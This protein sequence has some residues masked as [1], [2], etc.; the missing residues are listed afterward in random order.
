MD[1]RDFLQSAF[2]CAI[3]NSISGVGAASRLLGAEIQEPYENPNW[4]SLDRKASVRASSHVAD[5]PWG[6][7]PSNIFGG[8]LMSAWEADT[9]TSGAWIEIGFPETRSVRE[10]WVLS[11][12]LPRDILG[13]DVYSLVHCC[14]AIS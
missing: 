6:Y 11:K 7:A 3:S 5:P 1:R 13:Q 14:P 10:I 9:Q 8:D 2:A 4:A 12:A